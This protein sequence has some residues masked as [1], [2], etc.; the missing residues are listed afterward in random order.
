MSSVPAVSIIMTVYNAEKYVSDAI[1][2]VINQTF[3]DFEFLIID[4]GSSDTTLSVVR[5]HP[6]H[7]IKVWAEKHQNYVDLL[8]MA[9]QLAKGTYLVKMDDDDIMLSNRIE[10]QYAFMETHK[11]VDICGSWAETFGEECFK[12]QP[13]EGHEDILVT[14]LLQNPLIHPS[15]I[16]RRST[17]ERYLKKKEDKRF[18]DPAYIYAEDYKLWVDLALFGCRFA[19]IPQT[20]LK[21]RIS[22]QQIT[23]KY[24]SV[25]Y[26]KTIEIQKKYMIGVL[27]RMLKTS[28]VLEKLIWDLVD[29][30]RSHHLNFEDSKGLVSSIYKC[31]LNMSIK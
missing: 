9:V 12:M 4:D 24:Q 20:L 15:V 8:N 1:K 14:M 27:N 6:D 25:M 11:E 28:T 2:S 13:P 7:R 19:N 18:Y 16:M 10:L 3:S 21:Y 29:L 22:Q 31:F 17:I 30:R 26:E 23:R 5:N